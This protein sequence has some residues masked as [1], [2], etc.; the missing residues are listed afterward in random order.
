[1]KSLLATVKSLW[2]KLPDGV[3]RVIHT[4]WQVA[5]GAVLAYYTA[6]SSNLTT[7]NVLTFGWAG[8]LAAAKAVLLKAT[9]RSSK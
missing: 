6:H 3:R 8:V 1:M 9:N 2:D 4:L 7:H 5:L